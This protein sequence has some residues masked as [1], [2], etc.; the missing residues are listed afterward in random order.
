MNN[1][2]SIL[3]ERKI[4]ISILFGILGLV[5]SP[6]GINVTLGKISAGIPWSLF[7]PIIIAMAYGWRLG[8]LSGLSGGALFPFL[9]WGSNGWANLSTTLVYLFFYALIGVAYDNS[10]GKRLKNIPLRVFI[11]VTLFIIIIYFYYVFL[12]NPILNLNPAFWVNNTINH[13]PMKVLYG[14]LL[15]GS[16]NIIILTVISGTLI[17]LPI[18]RKVLSL[19]P[20]K[21]SQS[22]H[23]IFLIAMAISI[24]VWLSFFGLDAL[25]FEEDHILLNQHTL[26]SLLIIVGSG[27]CATL[28]LFYYAET[29]NKMQ[30]RLNKSEEKFRAIYENSN[31]AIILIDKELY[32]DCNPAAL[33]IFGCRLNDIIRKSPFNFSP[34][35][36]SDGELSKEKLIQFTNSALNGIPVR[37]EWQH[38]RHDGTAFDAEVSLSSLKVNRKILIQSIIRDISDRKAAEKELLSAKERAEQ[39]DRLK[40][41]F[42][43][44]MS[45]EIR[46]PLNSIIGFSELLSDNDYDEEM[47]ISFIS[48]IVTNGNNLL[49]I[50]SDIVDISKIES[51]EMTIRKSKIHVNNFLDEITSMHSLKVEEKQ[52]RFRSTCSFADTE[53]YI[54]ADKERLQQIFNNLISNALKFTSEGYIEMGCRQVGDMVEFHIKDTGIGIPANYHERIFD[55]FRQV[56]TS[57]TRKFGGNGLGLAIS[58]NLVVLM[59]G[60]IWVE[61]ELGKGST[62]YFTLPKLAEQLIKG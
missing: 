54:L 25:L 46:T 42:L 30:G 27:F 19:A 35:Y 33:K 2:S 55:R 38:V 50:I 51:G 20:R 28:I 49:N 32:I 3:A 41:A 31:D 17:R 10:I 45:H 44:N 34:L 18:V 5:L 36:Q 61:S 56:E 14:F 22:N 29:Q 9:L 62:F 37:F 16:V 11:V 57:I 52:L 43:A 7:F 47:K 53:V 59:G 1:F 26:L 6:Y 13:L 58:K 39:S 24:L 4:W 48:H 8:F 12:F 23:K 60:K 21:G 40:S 15:K